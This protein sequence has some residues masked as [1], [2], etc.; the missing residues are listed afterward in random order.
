MIIKISPYELNKHVYVKSRRILI[1]N[2][3]LVGYVCREPKER[4]RYGMHMMRCRRRSA[5]TQ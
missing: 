1:F 3:R 2:S 5:T 4:D